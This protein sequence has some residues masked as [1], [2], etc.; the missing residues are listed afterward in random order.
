MKQQFQT[1]ENVVLSVKQIKILENKV[2]I[3]EKL[4][5]T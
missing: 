4:L 3:M 1:K 2:D 5:K